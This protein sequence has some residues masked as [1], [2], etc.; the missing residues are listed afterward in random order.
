MNSHCKSVPGITAWTAVALATSDINM[1]HKTNTQMPVSIG[2]NSVTAVALVITSRH[3]KPQQQHFVNGLF[4]R[5][6]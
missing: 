6:I 2:G 5:T 1:L 4:F 3:I